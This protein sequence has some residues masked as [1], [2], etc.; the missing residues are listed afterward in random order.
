MALNTRGGTCCRKILQHIKIVVFD[1]YYP[2][3]SYAAYANVHEL[4]LILILNF[5]HLTSSATEAD[6]LLESIFDSSNI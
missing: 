6:C 4:K 1:S 2:Y 3:F 5:R